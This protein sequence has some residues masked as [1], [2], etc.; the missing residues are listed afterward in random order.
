MVLESIRRKDLWVVAILGFLV[1]ASAGMLG[2][3]GFQGLELFAKDLGFSV[4]SMFSTVVAVLT[5]TR[6][7][8]EELKQRTLYPLLARPIS[9]FDLLVGKLLGS[10]LVSWIGFLLLAAMTGIALL[11]FG[12]K[13]DLLTVQYLVAKMLGLVIVCSVGLTLSLCMTHAAG[14]TVSVRVAF[15]SGLIS[16]A[17]ILACASS[18]DGFRLLFKVL[19][20]VLPAYGLFDLGGRAAYLHWSPVAPWVILAL[21]AYMLIYSS[22][23]LALAWIRFRRLA[24]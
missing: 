5:S 20:G 15:A 22:S 18:S 10:I 21:A 13:F 12:V 7:M 9:R 1:I 23:M 16:R 17:L 2:I 8:P 19:N 3:F 14:C 24:I 11:W 4:L 6:V